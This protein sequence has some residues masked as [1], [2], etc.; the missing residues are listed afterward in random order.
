M[1]RYLSLRRFLI[2]GQEILMTLSG[3]TRLGPYEIAAPI[4]AGGMGEVYRARDTR[5]DRTVAI[6]LLPSC[7]SDDS[8]LRERFAREANA[9]SS[10]NHPHICILYDIGRHEGIGFLVMEYLEGE[11]LAQRIQK[12][13]LP[14]EQT[15]RYGIE[16][17]DALADAHRHGL[18]H[19]DLKPSNIMLTKSGAKLLDFGLAKRKPPGAVAVQ[20]TASDTLD[21]SL[22]A[23]GLLVGT[24][25]YMAPEQLEGREADARSD[26]FS[27]GAVMYEMVTGQR[28]FPGKSQLSVAS[29]I[30][31]KEPAPIN[32][33]KPLAPPAL[34]HAIRRCMA[35]DPEQRWQA[36][37]DVAL[38]LKWVAES[39]AQNGSSRGHPDR[40][41]RWLPW[42]LSALLA[43]TLSLTPFW[44][45][46]KTV[47]ANPPMRSELRLPAGSLNFALSPDGRRL[48]FVAPGPDGHNVVWIRE[49]ASLDGPRPL[50]GTEDAFAPVPIW[51]PNSRFVAF[52]SGS[53]LKKIDITGGPSQP[54]CD[55][56]VMALGGSWNR[57]DILIFG[58]RETGIM[59]VPAAGGDCTQVTTTGGRN[60]VHTFPTFLPDGRH[61]F[62]LKAPEGSGIYIGS[63]DAVP[64]RQS[65]ERILATAHM[66]VYAP[67]A[68]DGGRLLFMREGNLL[69]QQFDEQRLRLQGEPFPVAEQVGTIFLSGSFSV[70]A[71]G[72]LAYRAGKT[73]GWTSQL[74]WFDRNGKELGHGGEVEASEYTDIALSPDGTRLAAARVNPGAPGP[75]ICLVDLNRDMSRPLT[76]DVAPDS[77]PVWSPDGKQ[78]AFS[79]W[80]TGRTG[81][82][83]RNADGGQEQLLVEPTNDLN[84][85][86]DWSRDGR[87]LL[88]T[89]KKDAGTNAD[90]WVL[91]LS[92]DGTPSGPP[93][94]FADTQFSEHH[95]QFSPDTRWVAY[96]SN[97]SGRPEIYVQSFPRPSGG[98]KTMV[99]RGG[100]DQPRWRGDGRELFYLS[101][102][103]KV[104]AVHVTPAP[105]L[106]PGLPKPLFE[107]PLVNPISDEILLSGFRW[108]VTPDGIRFLVNKDTLSYE[109][110]TLV[111][112][113]TTDLP[114]KMSR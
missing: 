102:D 3:G 38:E 33:V 48:A 111:S 12:G 81:I 114:Q 27:L 104:M 110:L 36:A 21:V 73:P 2:S 92:A 23:P 11:S 30:L 50:R 80:R 74:K 26:I 103:K 4:G 45:R 87:F 107:A 71:A 9:V 78:V 113:W 97:E 98:G 109:S 63:L 55:T 62:Y 49:L 24:Y 25:Q 76:F 6:K 83:L 66:A 15:L 53:K 93:A 64:E 61:F 90:L 68:G 75:N 72:V 10:L 31:E 85:P 5:L 65:T 70:S 54:I 8:E 13:S 56:S 43:M 28:A 88:F 51:S 46:R 99:S 16:I 59:K 37:G 91:C 69:C 35:K 47:S 1:L 57:D 29:A 41:P 18:I 95:G 96:T 39:G 94:P 106:K 17:A 105:T 42:T 7:L 67:D 89:K 82:Y 77:A 108:D 20:A 84:M 101:L 58:T 79:A 112:N 60:E 100:G 86:N 44:Y 40:G 32:T 14:I 34:E 52:Q 22:T 19:R